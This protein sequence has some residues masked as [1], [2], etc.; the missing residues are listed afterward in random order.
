MTVNITVVYYSATGNVHALAEALAD[1]AK[2]EGAQVRLRRVPELAPASAIA[3]NPAWAAHRQR[4][5]PHVP[6][7]SHDDLRWAHGLA[8]GTP[9]R[10]GNVAAALKQFLDTCG[11]LWSAGELADKTFTGFVSGQ[12]RH[13]GQE[14]TL[15]A[16]YNS[17]Y[18]LGAVLVPP[19]YTDDA[20]HGAGGNPYGTSHP[21]GPG[22]LL[23][24]PATVRAAH[25]QGVRLTRLTARLHAVDASADLDALGSSAWSQQKMTLQR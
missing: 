20:V 9:V 3:A 15:L 6:E 23:P 1:G 11:G 2:S 12:S 18:H 7:V 13:G 5:S 10:F 22:G 17:A 16:L 21:S 19:G 25:Y 14:S 8:F 24:P 4:V